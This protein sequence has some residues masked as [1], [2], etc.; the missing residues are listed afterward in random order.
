MRGCDLVEHY[1]VI[2]NRRAGEI[3]RRQTFQSSDTAMAARFMAEREY[4]AEPD[5]EIVV[6]GA[7]S[8]EALRKTHSRYFERVQ[9]LA[10]SALKREALSA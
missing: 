1:L 7:D 5:I 2:Y 10:E 9:E 4:R 8:W 6:L 3:V